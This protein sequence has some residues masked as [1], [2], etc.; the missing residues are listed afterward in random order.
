M[1]NN[2]VSILLAPMGL[3]TQIR[4]IIDLITLPVR[5][6]GE[7]HTKSWVIFG[8]NAE[9]NKFVRDFILAIFFL[10]CTGIC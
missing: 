9:M 6:K 5:N 4:S 7:L 8:A 10:F 3:K 1:G 2:K